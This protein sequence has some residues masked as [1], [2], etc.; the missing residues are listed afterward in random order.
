MR[1]ILGE[2]GYSNEAV[3]SFVDRLRTAS[4]NTIDEFLEHNMDYADLGRACIAFCLLECEQESRLFDTTTEA[5]NWYRLLIKAMNGAAGNLRDNCVSFITF[6]YDRSLEH[7]LFSTFKGRYNLRD[8]RA[9]EIVNSLTI[10]HMY[11][12]L[13]RLPWEVQRAH[14]I[15]SEFVRDYDPKTSIEAIAGCI[16]SLR[17]VYD[18]NISKTP[19]RHIELSLGSYDRIDFIGFGYD[20]L[21]L[22]RLGFT[23]GRPPKPN[24]I[25]GSAYGLS[26]AEIVRIQTNCGIVLDKKGQAAVDYIRNVA[27]LG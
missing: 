23:G 17:I 19:F 1:P 8:E 21:N 9:A 5:T 27:E 15:Q 14:E 24:V 26:Q 25:C 4:V 10:R 20:R 2:L 6:N 16:A 11:G 12:K 22:T 18:K 3:D 13:G 7:F